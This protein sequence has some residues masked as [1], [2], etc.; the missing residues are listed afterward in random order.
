MCLLVRKEVSQ[1]YQASL[2]QDCHPIRTIPQ[3]ARTRSKGGLGVYHTAGGEGKQGGC[4]EGKRGSPLPASQLSVAPHRKDL[5]IGEALVQIVSV[6]LSSGRTSSA[7]SSHGRYRA[8]RDAGLAQR[9]TVAREAA[10]AWPT[11]PR[12]AGAWDKSPPD[13]KYNTFIDYDPRGARHTLSI[14]KCG[15]K[16]LAEFYSLMWPK[17][18]HSCEPPGVVQG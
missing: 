12:G 9:A 18:A 14:S 4:S 7:T 8:A 13:E 5:A 17:L 3:R 11:D 10:P 16:I 1:D 6:K 15:Q 2:R